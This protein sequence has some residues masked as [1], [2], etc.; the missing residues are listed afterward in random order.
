MRLVTQASRDAIEDDGS[1]Q[2]GASLGEGCAGC[3]DGGTD[4]GGRC[5]FVSGHKSDSW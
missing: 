3:G 1:T 5:L 4:R 2:M